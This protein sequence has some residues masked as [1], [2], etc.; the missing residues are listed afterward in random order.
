MDVVTSGMCSQESP[1]QE[2][3]CGCLVG[4]VPADAFFCILCGQT[5]W[6]MDRNLCICWQ[7][8]P[9]E[10][11]VPAPCHPLLPQLSITWGL[12]QRETMLKEP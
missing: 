3:G 6:E 2:R 5:G 1:C 12:S 11:H 9:Q 10:L 8:L 4:C 7:L